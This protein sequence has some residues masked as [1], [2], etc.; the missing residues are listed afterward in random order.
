MADNTVPQ[1]PAGFKACK[2]CKAAKPLGD[3]HFE[4]RTRSQTTARC[5]DCIREA[6]RAWAAAHP[7]R[8]KAARKKHAD[9][10]PERILAARKFSERRIALERREARLAAGK[11]LLES[12]ITEDGRRC[13][14]C[15]RRFPLADF[16]PDAGHY[17]GLSPYCRPCAARA[18]RRRLQSLDPEQRE[19]RRRHSRKYDVERL[20]GVPFDQILGIQKRQDNLCKICKEP[21]DVEGKR[22]GG[23]DHCHA[24]NRIRGILCIKC[25]AGIGQFR[26]RPDLL[27]AAATYLE[28]VDETLPVA[29]PR[30]IPPARK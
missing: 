17:D 7:D 27:R 20:Y 21:V 11:P 16:S 2:T 26:D 22:S 6:H 4:P 15:R 9:K 23:V 18:G 3:F 19:E 10:H 8:V 30:Y 1:V 14:G 5:R 12:R 13:S 29:S 24:T 28:T 25:N